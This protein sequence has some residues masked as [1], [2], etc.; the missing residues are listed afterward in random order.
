[1]TEYGLRSYIPW[2]ETR[3]KAC[4]PPKTSN[5][6]FGS[7]RMQPFLSLGSQGNHPRAG[8]WIN[9]SISLH[10]RLSQSFLVTIYMLNPFPET[11]LPQSHPGFSLSVS[12]V[13]TDRWYRAPT[14]LPSK[15][16]RPGGGQGIQMPHSQ[17][18]TNLCH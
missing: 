9:S 7:P 3:P 12:R 13:R 8:I 15:R 18:K 16:D 10:V 1:M 2:P 5:Q 14:S 17:N 6:V 4:V 11:Q